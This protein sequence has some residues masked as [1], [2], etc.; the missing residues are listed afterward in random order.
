MILHKAGRTARES[1]LVQA[2]NQPSGFRD[3]SVYK[4]YVEHESALKRFIYK[5]LPR[6]HDIEYISQEAFLKASAA[7]TSRYIAE[8]KS[9]LFRI[10]KHIAISQLRKN[11]RH[12]T[13]YIED[14]DC[15]DV[16]SNNGSAQD[17]AQA[18]QT[19]GIRCE[20][21]AQLSPQVRRAYLM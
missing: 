1:I 12:P 3:A 16:V 19:L 15:F 2:C 9:F 20:A 4:A 14:F 11:T 21:V 17:E 18:H 10:A 8:P 13:D 6:P 5:Y 7:E